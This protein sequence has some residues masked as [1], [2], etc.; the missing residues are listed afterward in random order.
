MKII[1]LSMAVMLS[2]CSQNV[3]YIRLDVLVEV[4]KAH[5]GTSR[6]KV[7][8]WSVTA[9]CSDGESYTESEAIKILKF[10]MR[11]QSND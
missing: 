4:C 9:V 1:L 6:V 10:T 7:H 11:G 8:K 3:A 2:A 5:G